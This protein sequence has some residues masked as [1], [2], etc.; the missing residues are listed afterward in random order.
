MTA[1]T[2]FGMA[3]ILAA[4]MFIDAASS[5]DFAGSMMQVSSCKARTK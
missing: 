3:M 2:L 1:F 4:L 5:L